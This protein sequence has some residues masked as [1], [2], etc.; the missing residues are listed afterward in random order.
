MRTS[1]L[2]PRFAWCSC[3]VLSMPQCRV[4]GICCCRLSRPC[5]KKKWKKLCK[6]SKEN[7]QGQEIFKGFSIDRLS[8]MTLTLHKTF[9][10]DKNFKKDKMRSHECL[11][12]LLIDL[13]H[14]QWNVYSILLFV[15]ST[16]TKRV[17]HAISY[18]ENLEIN[19][20]AQVTWAHKLATYIHIPMKV[21]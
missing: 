21:N 9:K 8:Q 18:W 16:A 15:Y 5:S 14:S 11:Y 1:Y 13:K 20:G 2:P 12:L 10:K 19:S 7:F 6:F 4:G 3:M 17:E